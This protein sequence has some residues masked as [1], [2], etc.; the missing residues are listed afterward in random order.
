V[1]FTP[2]AELSS[3]AICISAIVLILAL[4][5]I[6]FVMK[7]QWFAP[8]PFV[9]YYGMPHSVLN[10]Q[11]PYTSY[12]TLVGGIAPE[13]AQHYD[14]N[15]WLPTKLP[16]RLGAV[17]DLSATDMV[18]QDRFYVDVMGDVPHVPA[19][20]ERDFYWDATPNA[21]PIFSIEQRA[22]ERSAAT[23]D[24][25][26]MRKALNDNYSAPIAIGTVMIDGKIADATYQPLGQMEDLRW[27]QGS[28]TLDVNG[29]RTASD[30]VR[31]LAIKVARVLDR[32][33]LPKGTGVARF[34][35]DSPSESGSLSWAT[36]DGLMTV[37]SQIDPL[38]AIDVA[39]SMAPM[40]KSTPR[41]R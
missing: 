4:L 31:R 26:T 34:F 36:P 11:H 14:G 17:H 32:L 21:V 38:L 30:D 1:R 25:L 23:D 12:R 22:M 37:G 9:G 15:P 6:A 13:V 20:I 41:L 27:A 24:V 16:S 3:I 5:P 19:A 33:R 39:K 2:S 35:V 7:Y 8:R 29:S 40:K 18:E 28:W 10:P